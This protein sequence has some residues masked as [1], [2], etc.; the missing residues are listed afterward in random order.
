MPKRKT[1]K[2]PGFIKGTNKYEFDENKIELLASRF[3]SV[4]EIAAF[5][6]VD[7]GTIRKR[8]PN[9]VA[10]GR[11]KGKARLRDWQLAS[12]QKGNVV[13]LIWLG[14]NILTKENRK[15]N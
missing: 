15:Q 2:K 6:G 5:H 11:E 9:L 8:F 1:E 14:N 12:A 7:E 3:W 13:M 10:K 4:S